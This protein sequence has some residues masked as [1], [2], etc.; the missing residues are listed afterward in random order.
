MRVRR[1]VKLSP[2]CSRKNYLQF[3]R[4]LTKLSGPIVDAIGS[5]LSIYNCWR[6]RRP[7][8][9]MHLP[10]RR[11]SLHFG[12]RVASNICT[13]SRSAGGS[14]CRTMRPQNFPSTSHGSRSGCGVY[15]LDKFMR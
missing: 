11:H 5:E 10:R 9:R 2:A 6:G 12:G 4:D 8:E 15:I 7:V 14:L 1:S 13:T 3:D